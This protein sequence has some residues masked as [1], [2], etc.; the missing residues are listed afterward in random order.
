MIL[1]TQIEKEQKRKLSI[2]LYEF[3]MTSGFSLLKND[4]K[5]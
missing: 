3:Y 2:L 5:T 1:K 4:L